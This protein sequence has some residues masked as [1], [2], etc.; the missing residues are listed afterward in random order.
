[1]L[2][3]ELTERGWEI[4]YNGILPPEDE[5]PFKTKAECEEAIRACA[6][7]PG[8]EHAY[9]IVIGYAEE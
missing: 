9:A 6:A 4:S 5:P 2:K 7:Y 3:P 1:M 8:F